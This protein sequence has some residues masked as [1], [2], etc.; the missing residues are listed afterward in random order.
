M[1]KL[2]VFLKKFEAS[3]HSL[4]WKKQQPDDHS[5]KVEETT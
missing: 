5:F 4:K 1:A 3:K 2:K